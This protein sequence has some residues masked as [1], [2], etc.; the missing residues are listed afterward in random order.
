MTETNVLAGLSLDTIKRLV[1][2]ELTY[3]PVRL[4]DTRKALTEVSYHDFTSF[5]NAVTSLDLDKHPVVFAGI[6]IDIILNALVDLY[7][8]GI[9]QSVDGVILYHPA[10]VLLRLR[11]TK[12]EYTHSEPCVIQLDI[13]N[14]R[15]SAL[16]FP[17]PTWLRRLIS[18]MW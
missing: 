18:L 12:N 6:S 7:H 10:A 4:S 8:D 2:K 5:Q 15:K 9:L 17:R 16:A 13:R 11:N 1:D 3:V 14:L